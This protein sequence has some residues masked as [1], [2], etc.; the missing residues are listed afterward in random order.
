MEAIVSLHPY[1][2]AFP[3]LFLAVHQTRSNH[4]PA[5]GC[6]E[7]KDRMESLFAET[8]GWLDLAP[9]SP[10]AVCGFARLCAA[11]FSL[12]HGAG[13][14]TWHLLFVEVPA[15]GNV[16]AHPVSVCCTGRREGNQGDD[17][18]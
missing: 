6:D 16:I 13:R 5:S 14:V 2:L 10:Q 7:L 8:M 17:L 3:L 15:W 4:N 18:L 11:L 1:L 12:S 9:K